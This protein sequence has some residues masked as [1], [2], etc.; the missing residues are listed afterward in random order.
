MSVK[1]NN[2]LPSNREIEVLHLIA[3]EFTSKEIA[4]TLYISRETV[5]THRKNLM[6][7]LGARNVAGLIRRAFEYKILRIPLINVA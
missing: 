7:K 3:S 6:L 5:N 1:H 2:S 4:D